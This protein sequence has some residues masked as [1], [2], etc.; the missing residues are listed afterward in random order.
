M[1][2]AQASLNTLR[3]IKP[4]SFTYNVGNAVGFTGTFMAEMGLLGGANVIGRGAGIKVLDSITALAK[5]SPDDVVRAT[6]ANMT[7][8]TLTNV[9]KVV[10]FLT[11][12]VFEG[13][14]NPRAYQD[15]TK[16]M[17]DQISIQESGAYDN[18]IVQIDKQGEGGFEAFMKAY[19]NY[20][21]MVTIE[22]LG[23][24][25]PSSNVV[26]NTLEYMGT[27]QFM[28]RTLVGRMMRDYGFKTVN[29]ASD[30]LATNKMAWDGLLPEY[31][32]E[33]LQSGWEALITGDKPVFGT[34]EQ[35]D[36][37]VLGMSAEEA[38]ITGIAVGLFSTGTALYQNAKTRIFSD[39]VVIEAQDT[40]GNSQIASIQ[41]EVWDKF[42][43][44]IG[45]PKLTW[46]SALNL[47]NNANLS[48]EEQSALSIVFAKTRGK[49]I[50]EDP[51][52]VKWK[53][54][55]KA[56]VE[57]SKTVR[58]EIKKAFQEEEAK[59]T[60]E[61]KAIRDYKPMT[62]GLQFDQEGKPL[63]LE[64]S[65]SALE[66]F[67]I[68]QRNR[69]FELIRQNESTLDNAD[70]EVVTTTED[71]KEET[72]NVSS[73]AEELANKAKKRRERKT[74]KAKEDV[75]EDQTGIPSEVRE[76]Q[77]LVQAEPVVEAG[78]EEV[79]PSGVVQ[80]VIPQE[81][82]AARQSDTE[83]KI[84]R[85]DLFDGVGA[86]SS[87]LG[88]SDVDAVPISHSEEKGIEFVQ[89]ANPNTGSIDVIVTGTSDNDFVGYY[90]I[91]ENGKPTN[92]WSSKFEN[93]SRNK[94]NFKTMISG[95]Q[96]MLPEGHQYTEK[97]SISTD[98]L[99]VWNQQLERGYEL[100][101]DKNGNL[102]TN[103]VAINGDAIEN[104][105]GV[106]V[107]KGRF[108][109]IRATKEEFEIIKKALIPY[110]EKF[111]L[112][113]ENIKLKIAGINVP[114]A[115]GLVTIDLPVLLKSETKAKTEITPA[116]PTAE[117]E[118]I[119][120]E[121]TEIASIKKPVEKR[122][123]QRAFE[124]KHG[125]PHQKVSDINRNFD[126]ITKKLQKQGLIEIDC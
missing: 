72:T 4:P 93:Q 121:A 45:D 11:G 89:Y 71:G 98:G 50:L 114:G 3:S 108:E 125:V 82:I 86:F 126:G 41:K 25:L 26:K 103:E 88:G 8:E 58:E 40:D 60:E 73:K 99:R 92:K 28:K 106:D 39:K 84:K 20:I 69:Y 94:E 105:L 31:A 30:F 68:D 91:Y 43:S 95:I 24:H 76:G 63:N 117:A 47:I 35:G 97:T 124:E 78:K 5:S 75:T 87:Q 122:E 83:S 57:V 22:R 81:E 100:Q 110:M 17:T 56:N 85:K 6:T 2:E 107:N 65:Y 49:E 112:G 1:V 48:P 29:E 53:E 120:N 44:A 16:R 12:G 51:D 116:V 9:Q 52:Y 13:V 59:L 27:N 54:E 19:G 74:P 109:S 67:D 33:V 80:E 46:S 36:Y 90:R 10:G 111:G 37:R 61:Q 101:Y 18:L 42:N 62:T 102:I 55:N 7:A 14:A 66:K 113:A 23:A 15:V 79:S 38:K 64:E 118:S 21:G 34:D 115:K 96:A 70:M 119:F 32:E 104:V 77:E 123:A